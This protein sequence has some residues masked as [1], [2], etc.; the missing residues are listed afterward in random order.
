M[1]FQ[2]PTLVYLRRLGAR[3]CVAFFGRP[4]FFGV[5]GSYFSVLLRQGMHHGLQGTRAGAWLTIQVP[6]AGALRHGRWPT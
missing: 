3:G 6:L 4:A 1:F 2:H 5:I